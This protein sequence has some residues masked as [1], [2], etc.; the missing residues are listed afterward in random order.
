VQSQ[1]AQKE[2]LKNRVESTFLEKNDLQYH[3][4]MFKE[5]M[6]KDPVFRDNMKRV[7]KY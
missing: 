4:K 1:Q 3:K 6:E 2:G 5:A 7:H